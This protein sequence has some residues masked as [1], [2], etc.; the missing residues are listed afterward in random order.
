MNATDPGWIVVDPAAGFGF[1]GISVSARAAAAATSPTA[2]SSD[3][4]RRGGRRG[5]AGGTTLVRPVPAD[6]FQI[7]LAGRSPRS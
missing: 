6:A 5:V 1:P 3:K 4:R 2:D 7:G